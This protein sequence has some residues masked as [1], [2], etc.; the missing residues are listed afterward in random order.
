MGYAHSLGSFRCLRAE[1]VRQCGSQF[2][3]Q[4]VLGFLDFAQQFFVFLQQQIGVVAFFFRR[5]GVFDIE[6]VLKP[7]P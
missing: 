4:L 2:A 7:R 3:F 5:V 1:M 6:L